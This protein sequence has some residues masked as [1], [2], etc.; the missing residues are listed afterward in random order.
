MQEIAIIEL[1]QYNKTTT[2]SKP[3]HAGIDTMLE[4]VNE[5][6]KNYKLKYSGNV[7]MQESFC[8]WIEKKG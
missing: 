2:Y 1:V 7:E 8:Q 6:E 5:I 3:S 4:S